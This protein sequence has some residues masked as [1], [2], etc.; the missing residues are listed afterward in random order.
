MV[1]A[2]TDDAR[3]DAGAGQGLAVAPGKTQAQAPSSGGGSLRVLPE[4]RSPEGAALADGPLR[5][6]IVAVA[7]RTRVRRRFLVDVGMLGAGVAA[8]GLYDGNVTRGGL[9]WAV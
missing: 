5:S 2:V 4:E 3:P 1:G 9:P 8:A 7:L 6:R